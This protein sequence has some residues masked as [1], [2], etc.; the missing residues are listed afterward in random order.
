MRRQY[1]LA[2]DEIPTAPTSGS[3][4]G[5]GSGGGSSSSGTGSSSGSGGSGGSTGSSGSG[6]SGGSSGGKG[7][8]GGKG[9]Q[10]PGWHEVTDTS[11]GWHAGPG[12][13]GS[14]GSHANAGGNLAGLYS[15]SSAEAKAA[16]KY[17]DQAAVIQGQ[18]NAVN[19]ALGGKFKKALKVRLGNARRD[20]AQREE[21]LLGSYNE[22]VK[23]LED[24]AKDNE[25][26]TAALTFSNLTNAGRERAN[27]LTQAAMQGAGESD[28][29]ASQMMSL[30]NWSQ[31]QNDVSSEARTTNSSIKG[32]LRDLTDDIKNARI[33]S[34]VDWNDARE[35]AKN[36]YIDQRE[37]AQNQLYNLYAQQ[38]EL[39]G[40]ANEA[41]S[42]KKVR[43][44]RKKV[45]QLAAQASNAQ[46][47]LSGMAWEDPGVSPELM[48]W[49]GID[50]VGHEPKAPKRRLNST[51]SDL[52]TPVKPEGA[53]L[54]S[55]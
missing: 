12:T 51:T 19:K 4:S 44:Q 33:N 2:R 25:A 14:N 55:W 41:K 13:T 22:R 32:S 36:E 45:E 24:A 43:R 3:S 1:E 47:N 30:R 35:M 17:I 21:V 6:G 52:S 9:K 23:S 31:N 7:G 15:G 53:T 46:A 20:Y 28:L 26:S 50:D 29:L 27:A 11:P 38:A 10:P 49:G 37:A 39:Y 42:N 40:F 34:Q 5:S 18:I 54:R 48:Q 16:R 8:K